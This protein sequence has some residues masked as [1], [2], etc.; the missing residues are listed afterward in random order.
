MLLPMWLLLL[1][2]LFTGMRHALEADH[3]AAVVALSTRSAG[4]LASVWRGIAWGAGHTLSLLVVGGICLAAGLT[5]SADVEHWLERG[6]GLM[7]VALG[8]SVLMR[9]RRHRVHVH[10]HR[11]VDGIVHAHAHGHG[12]GAR[13]DAAAHDHRHP[14]PG[15]LRAVAVGM[16]HGMAGTAAILLL[17]A[18]SADNFWLGIG[19]IAS[20]GAGSIAG[21][22]MLSAVI[23][24]PLELSARRLAR[25]H[26]FVDVAV[27]AGTV[28]LGVSMLR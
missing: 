22:A 28:L 27:A 25:A 19:Y 11:H 2:G 23:S 9:L 8:A 13:R 21:M 3:L 24:V 18:A 7:L 15:H 26:G 4:R 17:T 12:V 1:L 16:V 6:V 5:I 14:A 20:F 10:V